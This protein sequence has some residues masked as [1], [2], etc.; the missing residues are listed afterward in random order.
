MCLAAACWANIKT[1]YYSQSYDSAEESG[2]RDQKIEEYI[3]GNNQIIEEKM[4]KNSCCQMPF[5]EW[6]KKEDKEE[7]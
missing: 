3:K 7:Y 5:I 4:L 2:F 6:N 1:I